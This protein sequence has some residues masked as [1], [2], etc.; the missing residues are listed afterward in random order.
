M[1]LADLLWLCLQNL[2]II[3]PARLNTR[4]ELSFLYY[5]FLFNLT[6][7]Q[8]FSQYCLLFLK[9]WW[10]ILKLIELKISLI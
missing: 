2:I 4:C 7:Q 8:T 9:Y 6:F 1:L 5:L 10:E 3:F